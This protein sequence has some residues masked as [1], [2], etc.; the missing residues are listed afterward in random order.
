V[1][2][3]PEKLEI[4]VLGAADLTI[5]L[6]RTD[7][8]TGK[9]MFCVQDLFDWRSSDVP[10]WKRQEHIAAALDRVAEESG[11]PRGSVCYSAR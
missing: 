8:L 11:V 7:S 6:I 4:K 9:L 2:P 1:A 3:W 10:Q 5:R